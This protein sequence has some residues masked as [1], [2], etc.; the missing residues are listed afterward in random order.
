LFEHI[1]VDTG[2]HYDYEINKI[3]FDQLE[4][5]VP[6]YFLGVGSGSHGY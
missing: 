5:P 1:I 6:H 2:Q 3:F 4:I